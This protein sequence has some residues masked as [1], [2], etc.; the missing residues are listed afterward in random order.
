MTNNVMQ[1]HAL[2]GLERPNTDP[3]PSHLPTWTTTRN[4]SKFVLSTLVW[5]RWLVG[6]GRLL[7]SSWGMCRSQQALANSI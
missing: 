6:D 7:T 1:I 3:A 4:Y 5:Q 2:H